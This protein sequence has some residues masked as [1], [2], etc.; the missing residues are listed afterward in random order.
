MINTKNNPLIL[1]NNIGATRTALAFIMSLQAT[2]AWADDT[3]LPTVVVKEKYN[4]QVSGY[5]S[6]KTT[7]GKMSQAVKDIPQS[8]TVVNRNLMD[9]RNAATL[10]EALRNVSGLT[11]NA[12]EGGRIG[13]NITIRGFGASSDLYLDGMRDNAQY[14]R[15]T[16]NLERVEVLRGPSS[17]LF[18]RGSTGGLVNQ[19]QK[20]A[21]LDLNSSV[22]LI[23]GSYDYTRGTADINSNIGSNSAVRLNLMKT[24]NKS[25]RDIVEHH[26]FG[27]APSVKF[28]IGTDNEYLLS[29]THLQY[30]DIPD[31]GIPIPSVAN[32]KPINVPNNTF[33]GLA[34]EDYQ[35]DSSDVFTGRWTHKIDKNNEVKTIL[36]DTHVKRDLR[37]T[38]ASYALTN[39]PNANCTTSAGNICRGRQA[40]GAVEDNQDIQTNYTSKFATYG[41][42][43]E[44]LLG[45]EYLNERASR[46]SYA[47]PSGSTNNPTT[48]LNPDNYTLPT[49]Y[50]GSF[51][52]I[53]PVHF[54]DTN[55]G[56]YG[57][58]L[59]QFL[60][61]WKLLLGFRYDDFNAKYSSRND[62]N[63]AL[64]TYQRR[65]RVWSYRS[66]LLYQPSDLATYYISYGTS[67]N[68]SGDLYAIEALNNTSLAN[69]GKIDPEK[70]I[71]MEVGAKWEL[72]D[73]KLSFRTAIFRT[74][75]TNERNTDQTNTSVSVLSGRRHTDGIE[76]ETSGHVTNKWEIFGGVSFMKS[77]IDK[78]VN[79]YGVGLRPVNT[80][81]VSGNFWNTYKITQNW[82]LGGGVDFVGERLGYSISQTQTGGAWV[83]PTIRRVPGYARVDALAQWNLNQYTLKLNILNVLDRNYYDSIYL[84]G[85]WGVPGQRRTFQ[86]SVGYK[87]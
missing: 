16:F 38:T 13:D 73:G 18:G 62:T 68:P 25:S 45:M 55:L 59:L 71:N 42:K 9:D 22:N 39:N 54:S 4:K 1:K 26:S 61:H 83:A 41:L 52:R 46:W 56:L 82:K 27:I 36:R 15:D 65:D 85:G 51:Q 49:N 57:Q 84:N 32:S 6:G 2:L 67:F 30:D 74:E 31:F 44:T 33:Y 10:Q 72:F 58:D 3:A 24:D 19:A 43:H 87:F 63:N 75:K 29:Y 50:G 66:G 81:T 69:A 37:A 28:G 64:T 70:S 5:Q 80:P 60:P 53:N 78:H 47:S 17:M 21:D 8:I 7:I 40:R 34:K 12:G 77:E 86:V 48:P 23:G 76:F 14:N 20:E 11:F 79:P 35:K